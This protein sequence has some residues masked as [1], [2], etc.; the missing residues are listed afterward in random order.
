M[1]N[2]AQSQLIRAIQESDH[3]KLSSILVE[4][5]KQLSVETVDKNGRTLL[6]NAC[7]LGDLDSVK[8]LIDYGSNTNASTQ[9]GKTPISIAVSAGYFPIVSYLL[10]TV[11]SVVQARD[12]S[13]TNLLMLAAETA[14]IAVKRGYSTHILELLLKRGIDVNE[15]DKHGLTALDRLLMTSGNYEAAHFL[16]QNGARLLDK[17][18]MKLGMTTLMMAALNGHTEVVKLLMYQYHQDPRVHNEVI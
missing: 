7:Q 14:A 6:M 10:Q 1:V 12:M 11:P 2:K 5:D 17:D 16:I 15:E 4:F 8:V 3:A 13:G 9:A 18:K